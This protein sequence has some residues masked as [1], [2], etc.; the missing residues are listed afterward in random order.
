MVGVLVF[1]MTLWML[2]WAFLCYKAPRPI[3]QKQHLVH[4]PPG[5]VLLKV[6]LLTVRPVRYVPT[7]C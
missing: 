5:S 6:K 3:E 4:V 7:T 2:G 1:I